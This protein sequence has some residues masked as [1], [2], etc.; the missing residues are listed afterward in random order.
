MNFKSLKKEIK[1]KLFTSLYVDLNSSYKNSVFLAGTGRS[2]TT[3]VSSIINY[4]NEY[5]YIFE[6]FYSDKVDAV[7]NFKYR[8]YIRPDTQAKEFIEPAR[9]ILSGRVRSKWTDEYNKKFLSSKRLVK[10]IRANLLLSWLH[11]NFPE[12]PIILLLRHPCAVVNS[13]L[14]LKWDNHLEELLA[15][16]ELVEDFL[17]PFKQEIARAKTDFEKQIFL[18]CIENYIPLKQFKRGE[19]HLAFYENFC[20]SPNNE[21]E[22]LFTFLGKN[23]DDTIFIKLKH[24]SFMS[25]K[26]SAVLTGDSIVDS[27]RKHVNDE[28]LQRAVEIMSL[29]GLDGIYSRDA[30]PNVSSAYAFMD[31]R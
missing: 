14:K 21:I 18:W 19:I 17:T 6:P 24:P 30:M 3:W 1:T 29:F 26:E 7:K 28:Q 9:D 2:G 22:R 15:Q 13:H 16:T 27:W 23:F 5:R 4:N 10:D 25:T 31:T 20:E 8:Q 11:N 12:V